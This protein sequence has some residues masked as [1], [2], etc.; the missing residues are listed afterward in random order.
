MICRVVV[1]I[2]IDLVA[3]RTSR[4]VARVEKCGAQRKRGNEVERE[5]DGTVGERRKGVRVCGPISGFGEQGKE[6]TRRR[7]KVNGRK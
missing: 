6:G 4:T 1:L 5:T 7:R 3:S 2:L